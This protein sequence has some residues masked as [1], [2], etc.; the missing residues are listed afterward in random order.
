[1]TCALHALTLEYLSVHFYINIQFALL[2]IMQ[3]VL[4][5]HCPAGELD[6]R[7]LAWNVSALCSIFV[8]ST[9]CC[10]ISTRDAGAIHMCIKC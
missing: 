2:P 4:L 5:F 8:R 6:G 1:M 3:V 10:L 7:H 9:C